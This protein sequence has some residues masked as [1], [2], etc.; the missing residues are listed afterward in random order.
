MTSSRSSSVP[1]W[2]QDRSLCARA[3]CGR[4]GL[5]FGWVRRRRT[6]CSSAL[7]EA[8]ETEGREIFW[9]APYSP[10][11]CTFPGGAHLAG[12]PRLGFGWVSVGAICSGDS[13]NSLRLRAQEMLVGRHPVTQLLGDGLEVTRVQ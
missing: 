1:A 7:S 9:V 6:K 12:P 11:H 4:F 3:K 5:G 10:S 8:D 13:M 2:P